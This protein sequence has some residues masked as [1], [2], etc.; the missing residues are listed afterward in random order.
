MQV[1]R[2]IKFR[3]WDRVSGRMLD[4]KKLTHAV[5]ESNLNTDGLFL[6][7]DYRFILLQYTGYT[8]KLDTDI[9]EGDKVLCSL[10]G[11]VIGA[12]DTIVF[13]HGAFWLDRR[14]RPLYEWF[15]LEEG[16]GAIEVTGNI[17]EPQTIKI[18]DNHDLFFE[19]GSM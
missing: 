1:N 19:N 3:A 10:N 5:L 15:E 4:L 6:P 8:D 18:T 13:K 16:E 7:F 12:D 11:A 14:N 2:I 9:Y 17:Y